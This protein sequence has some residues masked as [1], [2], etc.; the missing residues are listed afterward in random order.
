MERILQKFAYCSFNCC[1][2]TS[3][4]KL[5]SALYQIL[6]EKKVINNQVINFSESASYDSS[7]PTIEDDEDRI[8][9]IEL[10]NYES[11]DSDFELDPSE[12]ESSEYENDDEGA[13]ND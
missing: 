6:R 8:E 3:R 5:H 1:G 7:D 10:E 12:A 4:N 2:I 9:S 13:I 11:E